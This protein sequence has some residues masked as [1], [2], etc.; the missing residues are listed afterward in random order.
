MAELFDFVLRLAF[1]LALAM[2]L[3]SPRQ[4]TAGFY[5]NHSYVLLGL[6][7]LGLMV[8]IQH[9]QHEAIAI[10]A[11]GVAL[12]YAS[13]VAWL[14]ERKALGVLLLGLTSATALLGACHGLMPDDSAGDPLARFLD[15]MDPVTSGLLLGTTIAAM[16]LGHWYLNTP[17]MRIGPLRKLIMMMLFAVLLRMASSAVGLWYEVGSGNLDQFQWIFLALRW[18]SG[19]G[20]PLLLIW[21]AWKTLDIP[22][23]QSA[24]GI[25]Y[26][27]VIT[28]FT[29]ELTSLL[30]STGTTFPL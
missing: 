13:S 8:A 9:E 7:V 27:A 3:T 17:T 20:F 15:R 1:G 11:A 24:T 22:N 16:F 2:A 5:R 18:L 30:L 26:V 29:G 4:V 19:F 28:T 12:S 14:Y 25:L 10:A 6:F 23:T 21:M